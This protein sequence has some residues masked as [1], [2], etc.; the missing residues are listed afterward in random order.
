MAEQGC[1]ALSK[2][3]VE[4][5]KETTIKNAGAGLSAQQ[6][7]ALWRVIVIQTEKGP[8]E[9]LNP[10]IVKAS[11]EKEVLEEGCLSFPGFWLKIKRPKE[12]EV[13]ARDIEEGEVLISAKGLQS[14]IVQHE[15][16]H[17]DGVLYIDRLRFFERIKIG[18]K[19][20]EFAKK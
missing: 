12:V 7:G 8:I 3:D 16:D 17:L 11:K 6:V 13:R 20:K 15:I 14:R 9:L 2:T 4:S 1:S 19:I 5:M 10:V 18:K